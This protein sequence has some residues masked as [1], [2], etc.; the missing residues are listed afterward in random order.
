MPF[1]ATQDGCRLFY[2]TN[3]IGSLRPVIVFLNGT[4][5]NT[6]YWK[7]QCD[8]FDGL[9]GIL[10]YDARAQGRSDMGSKELSLQGHAA[11]L[12]ALLEHLGIE[13][14]NLVGLSHGAEVALTHAANRPE[15]VQR[16]VLCSVGATPTCRSS[17]FVRSWLEI[18]KGLG[19]EAMVWAALPVVLGERFLSRNARIHRSIVS[20]T[21]KRNKAEA[22]QAHLEA[23]RFYPPLSQLATCVRA[24]TLVMS[25]SDDPLVTKE[26]AKEL[27]TLCHGRHKHF[28]GIGHSVPNEAPELFNET[29]LEF[30]TKA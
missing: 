1:F 12:V 8:A 5:Q 18:I 14:V 29:L 16:L 10:T 3:G 30:L 2:E 9:F 26:A 22:L 6:V 23:M 17:V 28:F 4:M 15:Q 7:S 11:D 13:K 25:A 27:A 24:P 21:V 20:A 19:L